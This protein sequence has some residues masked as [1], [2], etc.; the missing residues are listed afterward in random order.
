MPYYI[1]TSHHIARKHSANVP[2]QLQIAPP[3]LELSSLIP[4]AQILIPNL[5]VIFSNGSS[6]KVSIN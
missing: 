1:L 5:Q 4:N 2:I 6:N 3:K